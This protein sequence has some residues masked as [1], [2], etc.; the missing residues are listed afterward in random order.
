MASA[1]KLAFV[2]ATSEVARSAK[3]RD[4]KQD[5]VAEAVV[6]VGL[7]CW[8]I[9]GLCSLVSIAVLSGL[10]ALGFSNKILTQLGFIPTFG[11]AGLAVGLLVYVGIS[12]TIFLRSPG[13]GPTQSM[14]NRRI[15]RL[16]IAIG[17]LLGIALF[18]Y[19]G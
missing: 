3:G 6:I 4:C 14:M 13:R 15:L 12:K 16:A 2:A 11:V 9:S 8:P 18:L 5:D 10:E 7:L 17:P 19:F 1:F